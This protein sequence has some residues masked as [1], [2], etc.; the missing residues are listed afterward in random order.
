M[1]Q[2]FN[3]GPAQKR[4]FYR[5]LRSCSAHGMSLHRMSVTLFEKSHNEDVSVS[6][7]LLTRYTSV[8]LFEPVVLK[9]LGPVILFEKFMIKSFFVGYFHQKVIIIYWL[10]CSWSFEYSRSS[11][12]VDCWDG[13]RRSSS[14]EI[15]DI[16]IY[17]GYTMTT[18]LLL[19]DVLYTI[20][21]YAFINSE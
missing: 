4:E 14:Q 11:F 8:I 17:H 18:K 7:S 19:R 6:H 2:I 15:L 16:V 13:A 5:L 20:R 10:S 21:H 9:I 3:R 1:F 12:T